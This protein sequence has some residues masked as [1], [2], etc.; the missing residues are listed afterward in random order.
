MNCCPICKSNNSAEIIY[1]LQSIDDELEQ[2]I[3]K[4]EIVL[5]G[6]LITEHDSKWKCN[7]CGNRWGEQ[8]HDS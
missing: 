8:V 1:G 7:K 2:A 5:G 3:K 4:K 6:C